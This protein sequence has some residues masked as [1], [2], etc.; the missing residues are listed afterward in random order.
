[1]P[2]VEVKKVP[3]ATDR[4]LPIFAELDKV[5]DEIRMEAWNL[6]NH[7]GA[8]SGHALDDWLEAERK[9]CWPAAELAEA[10]GRYSLKVALAGFE[11]RDIEVTATPQEII[12]K[13][14]HEREDKG[15]EDDARLKWTEFHR[16]DV[17]RRVELPAAVDVDGISASLENGMLAITAPKAEAG[18][19]ESPRRI[20]LSAAG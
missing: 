7:R 1:M 15:T 10:D 14:A 13:A 6:F 11:P 16:N 3:E 8:G 12:V 2:R 20:E 5:A 17:Y 18:K 19:Q 9:I 4:H